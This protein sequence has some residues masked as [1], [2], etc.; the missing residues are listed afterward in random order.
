MASAPS[1]ADAP[2]LG[3]A[4]VSVANADRSGSGGTIV[5]VVPTTAAPTRVVEVRL[6]G[7]AD[8][9]DSVVNLFLN[10]GSATW[11]YDSVDVG[12]PAAGSGTVE[13][14]KGVAAY[15]NLILP[16]GW[17]LRASITVA[18]TSGVVNV[19]AHGATL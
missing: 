14:Y 12:N 2:I 15:Q 11:F 4:A 1:F 17:S 3:V 6:A 5:T 16:V 9:A 8:V 13:P 19:F 18:P 7:T 10:D